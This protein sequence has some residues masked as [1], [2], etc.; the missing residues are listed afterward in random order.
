MQAVEIKKLCYGIGEA[1]KACGLGKT[2]LYEKLGSGEL[3]SVKIG[4]RRLILHSDLV[5]FLSR[6]VRPLKF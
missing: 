6:S 4:N 5:D 1:A 3:K 2:L